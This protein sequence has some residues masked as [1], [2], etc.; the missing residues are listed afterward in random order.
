MNTL[1]PSQQIPF[2][3]ESYPVDAAYRVLASVWLNS[4]QPQVREQG[5]ELLRQISHAA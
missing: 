5:L 4:S 3:G 2:G 1:I